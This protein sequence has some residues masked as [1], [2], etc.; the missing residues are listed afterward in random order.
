MTVL[1]LV[2]ALLATTSPARAA[3]GQLLPRVPGSETQA[4]VGTGGA[5]CW[6]S[7]PRSV[8]VPGPSPRTF[9]SWIDADGSIVVSAY[10]HST[11]RLQSA[12]VRTNVV[13]DDHSNPSLL[14]HDDG[15]V[16]VFWSGHNGPAIHVRTTTRP[17]D[18]ASFGPTRDLTSFV[19]GDSVVTYTNP[20]RVPGE[21]GR[22]YLFFRS[23]YSH[24]GYVTSEDDG[25]TWSAAREVVRNGEMRP[26]VKVASDRGA[27]IALAFTDGHPDELRS[28]V[29]YARYEGGRLRGADGRVLGELTAG[30]DAAQ[31]DLLWD[32]AA[33]GVSGWVHDVAV[34][35]DGLPVVVFATIR[36]AQ[37]HR[38]HWARYDG[39][40][41]VVRELGPAG[42]SIATDGREPS[43]SAG[44]SLDHDEP[45]V[46]YLA[47][48][49][50]DPAV[51]EIER[52]TTRDHGS[53]WVAEA[54][55][56]ASTQTNLRPVRPRGLPDGLDME[57]VWMSGAY[58]HFTTFRTSLRG[59]GTVAPGQP[60]ATTT[61]INAAALSVVPGS[62]LRVSARLVD[63]TGAAV[64]D[65][66]VTLVSRPAGFATWSRVAE[67]RTGLDGLVHF[68]PRPVGST[69]YAV[70]WPGDESFLPSR[71]PTALVR[72]LRPL[73]S[74]SAT[75]PS[76]VR[77]GRSVSVPA[78]LRSGDGRPVPGQR[79]QLVGRAPG[80]SLTK[81]LAERTTGADGRALL[82]ATLP[83]PTD[84][85]VR[86]VGTATHVG[87][88]VPWRRVTTR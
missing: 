62:S 3:D 75:V 47:R 34:G 13:V 17:G 41:W 24:Q 79:V 9:T 50:A 44:I 78:L 33:T 5:W 83:R 82:P 73:T 52:W 49:G 10:D 86:F 15:R 14:R 77:F 54:V 39:T 53:S 4:V 58:P 81:V 84:L 76:A 61:R 31:G 7:D 8:H 27:G 55:T 71:S 21:A 56:T 23:G 32:G 12:V 70:T 1:P 43:Y 30:I 67:L 42:G 38:Y 59:T 48:P 26:Y 29:R 22:L 11:R 6:F 45:S 35:P 51:A 46:V 64:V 28:S 40:S 69:E 18:V 63:P 72:S 37:D 88:A 87:S 25:V 85:Q 65:R 60:V 68:Q 74:L 2:A 80:T 16:S 66:E 57:A 19:P 36:S 20:V